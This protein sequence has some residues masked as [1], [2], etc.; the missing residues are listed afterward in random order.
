MNIGSKRHLITIEE[1]QQ[2]I[3]PTFGEEVKTWVEFNKA[4]A[5]IIPVSVD[6]RYISKEKN[7]TATHKITIRYIPNLS[8]K[9]R[10]V[11]GS[12]IFNIV[13]VLNINERNK[14]I[15]LI[16]EEKIDE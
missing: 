12:R 14:M 4:W 11:F 8:V 7:A 16:V 13:S 3:E 9:M 15:Q 2:S 6:E 1:F 10:V 5:S